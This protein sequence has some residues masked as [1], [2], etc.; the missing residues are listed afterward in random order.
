MRTEVARLVADDWYFVRLSNREPWAFGSERNCYIEA[1]IGRIWNEH[2]R[3]IDKAK[4][5]KKGR[6]VVTVRW[7]VGNGSVIPMTTIKKII[8]LKREVQ[9]KNIVTQLN[10]EEALQYLLAHD[11]CNPHQLVR[12]N[13]KTELRKDFF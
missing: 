10:T 11:F 5:D 2:E 6:A 8:L 13:R 7:I 9:D 12:D 3:L 4:F 1:D